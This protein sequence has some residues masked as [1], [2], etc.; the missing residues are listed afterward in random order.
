M[1]ADITL[2]LATEQDIP[3]ILAFIQGLAEYE[4]LADQVVAT[5]E[6][7]RATLFG[8]KPYAE[9][10]IAE[11]QQQ[12]AGF[13]LFFHNY[14]TFL[15][16]PGIYLEDL[17]VLPAHRGLGLGK[18]LLS[19]LAKLA[20]QRD[21]GRLEWSVLDWNQPAIDFYQAQGAT[22]LHDWRIN[23]VTGEQLLQLAQQYRD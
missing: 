18:L 16:K 1:S 7:L 20:V 11:Y 3:A 15:A 9:V 17:F 2:R 10:V 8:A 13:A 14:S 4:E 23:R 22:M 5:E 21:C 6:K 19:Y 12:A